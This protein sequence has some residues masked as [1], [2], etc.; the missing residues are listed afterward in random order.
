MNDE[1][2]LQKFLEAEEDHFKIA[3]KEILIGNK[4]S[5]WIWYIFPQYKGLVEMKHLKSTPSKVKKKPL[6]ILNTKF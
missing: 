6:N 3:L 1:F 5:Q 2:E 4:L